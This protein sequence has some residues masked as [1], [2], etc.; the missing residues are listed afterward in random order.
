VPC[1]AYRGEWIIAGM[2]V[3][4]T[5]G[6]MQESTR[7]SVA[8]RFGVN[9]SRVGGCLKPATSFTFPVKWTSLTAHL[10]LL[11]AA[12]SAPA[13]ATKA[14]AA[15]THHQASMA[16]VASVAV[17]P[18]IQKPAVRSEPGARWEMVVPKM[19]RAARIS[20]TAAKAVPYP[21]VYPPVSIPK[22]AGLPVA[23]PA[24]LTKALVF[25]GMRTRLPGR[26]SNRFQTL[27]LN[28]PAPLTIPDRHEGREL[29]LSKITTSL[30]SLSRTWPRTQLPDESGESAPL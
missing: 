5:A 18:A 21:E 14:A 27:Q 1:P 28:A 25:I 26:R 16:A 3:P 12:E 15:A 30:R 6:D 11:N 23:S 29:L 13:T 10:S 9:G 17:L 4:V 20:Q 24:Y 7:R 2:Q 8:P 22:L 19:D